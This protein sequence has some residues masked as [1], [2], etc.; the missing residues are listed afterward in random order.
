[1][2]VPTVRDFIGLGVAGILSILW[3]DLRS[4]RQNKEGYLTEDK[5]KLICE[6][7]MLRVEKKIDDMRKE[8]IKEIRNGKR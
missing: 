7:S 5:H 3:F 6:N 8:I 2:E 4:F 1:M